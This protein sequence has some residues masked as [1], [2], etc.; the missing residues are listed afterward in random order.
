MEIMDH[1]GQEP[2]IGHELVVEAVGEEFFD[3]KLYFVCLFCGLTQTH[4]VLH[5]HLISTAH[6][7][8]FLVSF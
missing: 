5:E 2:E 1:V 7:L 8:M 4:S 6:R 3:K